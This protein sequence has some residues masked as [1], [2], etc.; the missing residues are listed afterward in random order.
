MLNVLHIGSYRTQK[1]RFAACLQLRLETT[2][3]STFLVRPFWIVRI[4]DVHLSAAHNTKRFFPSGFHRSGSN[5]L[6]LYRI[7]MV[8]LLGH[9]LW[10]GLLYP[11]AINSSLELET[12]IH[13]TSFL[14]ELRVVFLDAGL[15]RSICFIEASLVFAFE[16]TRYEWVSL[17][18]Q[19]A[20]REAFYGE[21]WSVGIIISF[22]ASE[23]QTKSV[24]FYTS[25]IQPISS[26]RILLVTRKNNAYLWQ[27]EIIKWINI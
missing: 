1:E 18:A 4:Q 27:S 19:W 20:A 2:H 14:T 3:V 5:N 10:S 16:H 26:H 8:H 25:A 11:V 15:Y 12:F 24:V 21:Y 9:P 7:C 6:T 22:V 13:D 23:K 17:I